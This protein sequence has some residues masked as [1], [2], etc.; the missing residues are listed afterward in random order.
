MYQEAL[1]KSGYK[2]KLIYKPYSPE[3]KSAKNN[4][5]RKIIWFNLPYSKSVSTNVGKSFLNLVNKHFPPHHKFRKLF[6]KNTMKVSYSCMP[7]VKS[8]INSHNRYVL[9]NFDENQESNVRL[10]N[11]TEQDNSAVI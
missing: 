10:C 8:K 1:I 11:C 2:H 6:N 4:S 3:N 5:K 9:G 7:S